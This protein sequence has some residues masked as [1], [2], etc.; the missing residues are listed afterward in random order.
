MNVCKQ[1][2]IFRCMLVYHEQ[3]LP[4]TVKKLIKKFII[5]SGS[6][7]KNAGVFPHVS[8]EYHHQ[9]FLLLKLHMDTKVW[10][11]IKMFTS[12]RATPLQ[13][14]GATRWHLRVAA[15]LPC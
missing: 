10:V 6:W 9:T 12:H 2:Y 3:L 11:Q 14:P 13:S 15:A 7:E 5:H 8:L 4:V 1:W